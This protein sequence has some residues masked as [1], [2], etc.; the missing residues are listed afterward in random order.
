VLLG[1][2][3][4]QGALRDLT[5]GMFG[6][7]DDIQ[8]AGS[9]EGGLYGENMLSL[10]NALTGLP[11][12][13]RIEQ[14]KAQVQVMLKDEGHA[15]KEIGFLEHMVDVRR[16]T[17]PEP[18][19]VDAQQLY[20]KVALAS[21]MPTEEI[22]RLRAET[23][24]AKSSGNRAGVATMLVLLDQQR[25]FDM[26]CRGLDGL[27]AMVPQ[28]ID[29]GELEL[30]HTVL[31]ELTLRESRSVQPWPELSGRLRSAIGTAVSPKAMAALLRAVTA[32]PSS[33]P[34]AREIARVA[35]DAA[36]PAII[37]EAIALKAEGLKA[38][39][40]MLGRRV[41]DLLASQLG[42][43]QWYQLAPVVE[44]L[45]AETDPRAQAA[46]EAASRRPDEQSRREVAAGLAKA[47]TRASLQLLAHMTADPSTEVA[48]GAVRALSTMST[49]GGA[50]LLGAQ[51]DS[52][53][54]DNKDYLL[55]REILAAL[56]RMS[57]PEADAVL[58]RLATR[59]TL[60][61]RGHHAEIQDLARQ[62]IAH[63]GLKGTKQ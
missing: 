23:T 56:A 50:A 19:L 47:D 28:L 36:G 4:D 15:D 46:I 11:L 60:I 35:G 45:A 37:E 25:D 26:Y 51:L 43:A 14:V 2:A 12:E 48:I 29:Q 5:S 41:I 59:K 44:R 34:V 40:D 61:K 38:A 1:L 49:P 63:R 7:L 6:R 62:A 57:D 53:D 8:I 58:H 18:A 10:S 3:F 27:A 21:A 33:L 13:Q 32:D 52:L 20:R 9:V 55:G 39:E 31:R 16:R 54:I 22:E 17:E 30:A 24:G 42:N